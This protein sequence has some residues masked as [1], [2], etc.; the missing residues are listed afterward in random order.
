MKNI[1]NKI[2][3]T[4]ALGHIGASLIR[5][6]NENF[7][8]EILLL[9]NLE[10]RRFP[11]LYNLPKKKYRYR[12]IR[13]DILTTDFDKHLKGVSVV[14]HL[15]AITDAEGSHK[16]PKKV[17]KVNYGG[18]RRV[19][20]ACLKNKVKIL[21]PSTTSVYGSQA[22]VVDETCEELKPQSPYAA[23]KL[24]SEE[25]LNTLKPKGLK[26]VICRFGTI[27]GHS[28]GMRY[29]TAVNRFTWQAATGL[30]ITVWKTAWNQK[31][32]YLYLGDCVRA[33]NFIVKKDLFNGEIY[34]VLTANFAV[35]DVVNTI[36]KFV[37]KLTVTYV[38]SPIMN[39]LSYNVDDSKFRELGF[40]PKG[41][42][43]K[44]ISET[45]SSLRK[46]I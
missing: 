26:F 2:L 35:K 4:G 9:D 24:K 45:I 30:P 21:F 16:I 29:D 39:Q 8:G 3:I 31:R 28:I 18:L 14:I 13:D 10:S 12:F 38:D 40:K 19:A 34:N 33:V 37:P 20:D 27:F 46:I 32:P 6:I 44:G 43:K 17:E 5:N 42:L 23:A 11:S 22:S 7:T 41:N 1:K 15:A 25:Y 36:K